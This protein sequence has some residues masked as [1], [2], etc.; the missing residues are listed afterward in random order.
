MPG[1]LAVSVRNQEVKAALGPAPLAEPGRGAG[2]SEAVRVQA[3]LCVAVRR[4][5]KSLVPR[6]PAG[7]ARARTGPE[8]LSW[9]TRPARHQVL[10][11]VGGHAGMGLVA[12]VSSAEVIRV[13]LGPGHQRPCHRSHRRP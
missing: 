2:V 12:S 4:E 7:Q 3:A 5:V 10:L 11:G 9:G 1:H 8:V 13:S 6:L